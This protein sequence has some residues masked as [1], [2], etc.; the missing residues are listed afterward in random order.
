MEKEIHIPYAKDEN[1]PSL[2]KI[3]EGFKF[4]DS[5]DL[6]NSKFE[7]VKKIFLDSI[8]TFP[9]Y[10]NYESKLNPV[11][12]RTSCI[13]E[14]KFDITEIQTFSHPPDKC[15]RGRCNLENHPVLYT[16]L[17]MVTALYERRVNGKQ[18]ESGEE[19]YISH[20]GFQENIDFKYSQFLYDESIKL[21]EYLININKRLF[22]NLE[23][24]S[25]SY[26]KDKQEGIFYLSKKLGD[27]FINDADYIKSSF[28]AH[29]HLYDI[30]ETLQIKPNAIIY[31]SKANDL[32]NLNFAFYPDFV[33]NSMKLIEVDKIRFTDFANGGANLSLMEVGIPN[34][35]GRI[36]WHTTRFN[37]N[38]MEIL[39]IECHYKNNS[40]IEKDNTEP[41]LLLNGE[42]IAPLKL[43]WDYIEKNIDRVLDLISNLGAEIDFKRDYKKV[44]WVTP[45]KETLIIKIND[46]SFPVGVLKVTL[47][48]KISLS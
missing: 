37:Q 39:D 10:I 5:L 41:T 9:K 2:N 20:W 36:E 48:Y 35:E 16:S 46:L 13:D 38:D 27:Y 14:S 40:V 28:L 45:A 30:D 31:P 47:K 33:K 21:G 15:V 34:T 32:K 3:V 17:S 26:S 22:E 23:D 42:S 25:K 29:Y 44:I 18:I 4:I 1:L 12:Y 24:M 7:E 43:V 11:V 6:S 19:V 8:Q